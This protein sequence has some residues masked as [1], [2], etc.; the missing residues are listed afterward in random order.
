[1]LFPASGITFD[2]WSVW[3]RL[4]S[5]FDPF[6]TTRTV[7]TQFSLARRRGT[8][9]IRMTRV[10]ALMSTFLLNLHASFTTTVF[11]QFFRTIEAFASWMTYFLA[12]VTALE[13]NIA[14]LTTVWNALVAELISHE[15]FAAI[16]ETSH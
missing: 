12:L 5:Y 13:L 2:R 6:G 4:A 1:M 10:H 7:D 3:V 15:L 9:L 8:R 11:H 16:A 14:D